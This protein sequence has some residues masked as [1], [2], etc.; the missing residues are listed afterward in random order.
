MF[1]TLFAEGQR[2]YVETFSAYARQFLDRMDK[3]AVDR[4]R[5][6]PAIAIDQT[7]PV[8]SS[9]ST[10]GTMT[11]LNDH[12]KLLFAR[13]AHLF[14]RATAHPVR[15][16]SADSIFAEVK[17]RVAAATVGGVE[18]RLV[19]TFPVVLPADTS[20][21]TWKPGWPPA[22]HPCAGP[23]ARCLSMRP[24]MDASTAA[25]PAAGPGPILPG[26]SPQ[27]HQEKGLSVQILKSADSIKIIKFWTWWPT[28]SA[29]APWNMP[30]RWRRW[31]WPCAGAT[32][33]AGCMR[34]RWTA[35]R[36]QPQPEPEVWAFSA[37][38][39]CPESGLSYTAPTPSLF[40]FN[41][42][43]GACDTCRGLA[44]SSGWTT[45]WSSP[46]TNSPC[47]AAPSNRC[48]P[49]LERMPGRPDAPRRGRRHPRDTPWNKLTPEQQQWVIGGSPQWNGKWNQSWYGVARFFEY[50]ETK[51]YK[52]HIRVLL[53]KYRSYT[54]CPACHGAR[55]N[56]ESLLWRMG[57]K[58]Q[59]DAVLPPDLRFCQPVCPGA[60]RS[61]KPCR[62]LGCTI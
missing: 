44:A 42:A 18:P 5:R 19:V 13:G 26:A 41:S 38:L 43:Q 37:S 17:H 49:R 23:S 7:N 8:R 58:A 47:A 24:G 52:M 50:L 56:T 31:R 45:G 46:T 15:Q 12:L 34:C 36:P 30:A 33:S 4:G 35:Q 21:R 62:A 29:S 54:E 6:A 16:D 51:A 1:D 11:E 53:S 48:K 2:R 60:G 28:A 55:L 27:N 59:A 25:Q 20:A 40:S 39:H 32:A 10:V 3:P 9:R 22:A 57:T 61:W 14:D